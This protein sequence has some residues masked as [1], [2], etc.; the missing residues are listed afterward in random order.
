[1]TPFFNPCQT[2]TLKPLPKIK[3]KNKKIKVTS[4]KQNNQ[5][6]SCS[7]PLKMQQQRQQLLSDLPRFRFN[8]FFSI[9][10]LCVFFLTW[11]RTFIYICRDFFER[12]FRLFITP[13]MCHYVYIKPHQNHLRSCINPRIITESLRYFSKYIAHQI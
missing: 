12:V 1:M 5:K 2:L 9:V 10:S 8:N 6:Y 3:P 11:K 13:F 4:K 7:T